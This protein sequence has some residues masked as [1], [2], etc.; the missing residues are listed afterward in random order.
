M[1]IKVISL[2]SLILQTTLY[3]SAQDSI[4]TSTSLKE[5][6]SASING[7]IRAGAYYDLNRESIAPFFSSGFSDLGVK[8]ES[9][10]N[11]VY[12]AFADIRFLYGSEF[13]KPVKKI[14]IKEAYIDLNGNRWNFSFGQKILKW[15]RADFTNPTSK[16]NPQNLLSRSPDRED[17]D[18]GN[19]LASLNLYP[20]KAINIQAVVVPFY[21]PSVL[22]IDPVPLP[23]NTTIKQISGLITDQQLFSYGFKTNLYLPGIDLGVSW[24]DGYDPMPGISLTNFNLDLTGP[25]PVSVTGLSE[26]PYKTKVIGLDFESSSGPIGFRGEAAWSSPYLSYSLNE[27]VPMEEV[28]WVAGLDWSP[29]NWRI[30]SEYSGKF[31]PGFKSPEVAPLIGTEPDYSL[32]AGMMAVPGFD[33]QEYVRRQVGSFNRL[34]NYQLKQYYHSAGVRVEAELLYGKILPSVYSMY[35]FTSK[36]LIIIP[37]IRFKPADGLTIVAGAELFSG[38]KGSLYDIVNDFM[39]TIYVA[40]KVNF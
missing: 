22:I 30:T 2:V 8:I 9:G 32:L 40:L 25:A 12:K 10:N 13:Q 5:E 37:E 36:D 15:G 11:T 6:K 17:M 26:K 21:R 27:Y 20:A 1:N 29:G 31:I 35:N 34:F 4:P 18:M 19:I 7:F 24:F 14:E 39:N 38:K 16:F 28:K 23:E 33:I 3:I